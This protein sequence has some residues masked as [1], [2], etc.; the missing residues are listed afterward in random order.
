MAQGP[1]LLQLLSLPSPVYPNVAPVLIYNFISHPTRTFTQSP[2][3]HNNMRPFT[4]SSCVFPSAPFHRLFRLISTQG[5]PPRAS[6]EIVDNPHFPPSLSRMAHVYPA[7][8]GDRDP[9][10]TFLVVSPFSE[11]PQ[12]MPLGYPPW[13]RPIQALPVSGRRTE[14]V[15]R[16]RPNSRLF[17]AF[18]RS[19]WQSQGLRSGVPQ[20]H[21]ADHVL[22]SAAT[23]AISRSSTSGRR[24]ERLRVNAVH[25]SQVVQACVPQQ[26]TPLLLQ[27]R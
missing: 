5:I 20:P 16:V 25:V 9:P 15:G 19:S 24:S 14:V 13:S 6:H 22:R 2:P 3:S 7:I 18:G 11:S 4:V 12:V 21:P 10:R 27:V 1:P 17:R 23:T 26:G 8:Q